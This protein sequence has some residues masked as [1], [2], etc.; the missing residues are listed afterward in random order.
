MTWPII[1]IST[2]IDYVQF[3]NENTINLKDS[4]EIITSRTRQ[5]VISRGKVTISKGLSV[6]KIML[7]I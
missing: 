4:K 3:S 1:S 6:I 7:Q 2:K 5:D